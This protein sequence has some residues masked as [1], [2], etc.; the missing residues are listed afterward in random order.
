VTR[1]RDEIKISGRCGV[2]G[3]ITMDAKTRTSD[4]RSGD[5][6]GSTLPTTAII[7][8]SVG[9]GLVVIGL[10]WYMALSAGP[11]K[12]E[13]VIATGPG[14]GTYHALGTAF[15]GMLEAN[16]I[17]G[18]AKVLE[19]DGSAENMELIGGADGGADFALVQSDTIP[20][21][22]TR[23][24]ASLYEEHLHLLIA[25]EAEEEI[26]TIR[27][28]SG[29]R[30]SLGS[31][32]SGSRQ[33]ASRVLAHFE[34]DV[35]EDVAMPPARVAEGFL[36]SEIDAAFI[37]TAIPSPVVQELSQDD[38]VR[39]L[40]LG[41]AQ[42]V[43]NEADALVLVHP[44][45][46]AT[47]IPHSTYGVLPE[48]PILTVGVTAQLVASRE[49]DD[50]L[51]REATAAIFEN[52]YRV[53]ADTRRLAVAQRI[54]ENYNPSASTIPYHRGAVAY[55]TRRQPPFFVEYAET[56]SLLLTVL[57][58]LYSTYIAIR[59][60]TRRRRKNRIDAFYVEATRYFDDIQSA[61]SESLAQRHSS[62]VEL[63][64]R[65]FN[66]LVEERLDANESFT[67]L[68]D[69]IDSELRSI[70]TLIRSRSS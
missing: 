63:R 52:R 55:Y 24:V 19:T 4:S 40:P 48:R 62:L 60:W 12:R 39:F 16:G 42:E 38:L 29:R 27:D 41:D 11:G 18:T 49:L 5:D 66:D 7:A 23:L 14:N 17:A 36:S 20:K 25:S 35:G 59:E 50:S 22:Q 26:R 53:G 67:I 30:V 54:R 6:V 9:F 32:G 43:G 44:S 64:R 46:H 13:I 37:L 8:A 2:L 28:L 47:T 70:E 3:S 69:Q 65:A 15:G 34:I 57:V 61:S 1:R 10:A 58:G 68:Q 56:M 33:V 21:S 45:L 51:V 31:A